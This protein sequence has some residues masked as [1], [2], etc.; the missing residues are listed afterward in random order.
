MSGGNE[1]DP[2]EVPTYLPEL[3]QAE[4]MLITHAHVHVE[5]KRIRGHQYQ[6]T[7]HTVCFI[8]N[9]IKLY[10]QCSQ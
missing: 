1:M 8:N 10:N 4:E 5:A 3:S 9:T 7:G 2:G 6:Y